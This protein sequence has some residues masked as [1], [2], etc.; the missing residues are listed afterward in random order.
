[1]K[2]AIVGAGFTGLAAGI[3]LIDGGNT[4]TIFEVADKPGGL[5][6]GFKP[7]D[8]A[9]KPGW[10]WSLEYFYHHIFSNDAEII[11]LANKVGWPA[12]FET[13]LTSSFIN[14]REVQLDSPISLLKFGEMSLSGRLWMGAGLA[15]L[16]IIPN[17]QM[18]EKFK[19]V[20]M[21]PILVGGEGYSKVWKRL[22]TAKFGPFMDEVNMAWFWAR[23]YK[24]TAKLGYFEGGFG[25]LA[26]K[27]VEYIESHGGQVLLDTKIESTVRS[28]LHGV[29]VRP[30]NGEY[31]NFDKILVTTPAPK[32]DELVG[33]DKIKWPKID[34]LWGQTLVLE[35]NN[36]LM[37][38]Y[39]LNILEKDWPF[40][41]AVEHTNFMDKKHYGDKVVIYLG[42]YLV[43]GDKRLGMTDEQ[44]FKLYLPYIKKI[45]PKFSESWVTRK[46]KWQAPFAQPVFPTNYSKQIPGHEVD[47]KTYVANMSMVYPF[48]RGTNYAVKMGQDVTEQFHD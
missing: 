31:Q 36:S 13:P 12:F 46:W 42:N 1:M 3:K 30:L 35:L 28:D 6:A 5:A 33:K 37:K 25:K 14:G 7:T 47:T 26:E 22:L 43:D 19:V 16:K 8:S 41:V 20:K 15:I 32:V 4:V 10:D 27:C 29:K 2:V 11:S 40:L 9:G 44:L 48:D 18:L 24:R 21:L 34:Y 38:S 17:G 39:W 23:V 45:N